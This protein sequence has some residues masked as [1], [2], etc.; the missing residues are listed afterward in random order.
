MRLV[1]E[2]VQGPGAGRTV[3]RT[4]GRLL[5]VGRSSWADLAI[6]GDDGLAD[7]HFLVECTPEGGYVRALG[8][9]KA[10]YRNGVRVEGRERLQEGDRLRAGGSEFLVRLLGEQPPG[11]RIDASRPDDSNLSREGI[12]EPPLS[13]SAAPELDLHVGPCLRSLRAASWPLFAVLDAARTPEILALLIPSTDLTYQSLYEGI[14]G[15]A[16]GAV[17][18]YLV[19]LSADSRLLDPLVRRGWGQ[20]WGI[21]LTSDRPFA[22]VRKHLRRFLLV[23]LEG[24]ERVYFRFY[25]PRVLRVYLPSCDAGEAR[26]FFGPVRSFL[27]EGDVAGTIIELT[28]DRDG[29]HREVRAL[30]GVHAE[31]G[32]ATNLLA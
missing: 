14:Q 24:G 12:S 13:S 9:P 16:L 5:Q 31:G 29:V 20:S 7:L 1:L 23:E 6:A 17:A 25:D 19:A 28:I 2:V 4:A 3:D 30:D 18:P 8:S 15:D 26:Q 21:Y 22:E 27:I 32:R 10:T 11:E